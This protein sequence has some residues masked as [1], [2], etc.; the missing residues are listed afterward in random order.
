[1]AAALSGKR[2]RR[3]TASDGVS[4]RR[5]RA[6]AER[7][8]RWCRLRVAAAWV[9]GVDG[10][11]RVERTGCGGYGGAVAVVFRRV[12]RRL[13]SVA[14]RQRREGRKE[15]RGRRRGQESY[16]TGGPRIFP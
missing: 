6:R 16:M 12:R 5:G 4:G 1:V 8:R 14:E 7:E 3:R 2:W 10:A 15:N 13:E 11:R 9:G